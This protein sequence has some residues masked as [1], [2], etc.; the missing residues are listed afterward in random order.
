MR[1]S[2]PTSAQ[3]KAPA[4]FWIVAI[5]LVLWEAMGCYA[6]TMQFK[7]AVKRGWIGA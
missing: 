7:L 1:W 5:L 3:L 4:W 2:S 6:C